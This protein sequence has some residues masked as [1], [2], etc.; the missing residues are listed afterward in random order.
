MRFILP[1]T[2]LCTFPLLCY[3]FTSGTGLEANF[4]SYLQPDESSPSHVFLLCFYLAA[5]PV[6]QR[7]RKSLTPLSTIG[8]PLR[9]F[10]S[11][12]LHFLAEPDH[13]LLSLFSYAFC[14]CTFSSVDA[15]LF[16]HQNFS[17]FSSVPWIPFLPSLTFGGYP[18]LF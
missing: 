8:T 9:F 14:H 12:S 10:L 6:L 7:L 13:R 18:Q 1:P 15:C 16:S 2:C 5:P 4:S 11:S 3:G 17:S